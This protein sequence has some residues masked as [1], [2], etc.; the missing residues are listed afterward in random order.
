MIWLLP[1]LG[2]NFA[3]KIQSKIKS[4]FNYLSRR[5]SHLGGVLSQRFNKYYLYRK[6][7]WWNEIVPY[8]GGAALGGLPVFLYG[9]STVASKGWG[10]HLPG[11]LFTRN[12]KLKLKLSF[13][14][15]KQQT[16][17]KLKFSY[18]TK[19]LAKFY[20]FKKT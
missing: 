14:K 9:V 12:L 2:G 6:I 3:L 1:D 20:Q 5:L 8:L 15:F 13:T 16:K 7:N 18:K 11:A 17:L 19:F 4:S 10:F